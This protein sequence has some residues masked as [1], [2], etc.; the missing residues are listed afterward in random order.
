MT[1]FI[2]PGS[3]WEN[4]YDDSFDDKLRDELLNGV[5][6]YTLTEARG[7]IQRRR[8]EHKTCLP[9]SP[10][11]CR[12]PAPGA[13]PRPLLGSALLRRVGRRANGDR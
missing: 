5:M 1:S 11:V 8:P 4:G 9:H 2:E 7:P 12:S 10:L 3:P 13:T 6:I